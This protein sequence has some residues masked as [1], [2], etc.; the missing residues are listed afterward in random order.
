MQGLLIS[1]VRLSAALTLYGWEQIQSSFSEGGPSP[2]KVLDNLEAALDSLTDVLVDRIGEGKKTTFESVADMAHDLVSTSFDGVNV[3]DPRQF[4]RT[5][6]DILR[7]SSETV[8]EWMDRVSS[9]DGEEPQP[10]AEVL[11][12]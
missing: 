11:A 6:D 8:A 4:L 3:V 1:M 2:L 5:T 9:A 7:A 10:A 12:G